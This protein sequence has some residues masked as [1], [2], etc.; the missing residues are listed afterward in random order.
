MLNQFSRTPT[1]LFVQATRP[2]CR[3]VIVREATTQPICVAAGAFDHGDPE[4]LAERVRDELSS[5]GLSAARAVLLLPRG[6]VEVNSLRLPPASDDEL[7]EMVANML[8]QQSD[9]EPTVHDFIVSDESAEDG[10][11][12]VL[13]FSVARHVLDTWLARFRDQNIRLQAVT[14]G[15]I[16]AVRLLGEVSTNPA[17]T[18]VVV[19][20]TD[21]D[22]DLVVIESAR[23][24]LFRTIPRATGGEQ[25]VIDQLAGDIQRTLNLVG[26]PN[27]EQTRVYLIGTVGEQEDAAKSLSDKLSLSVS[28]VNPFE[29]L[30]GDA[31]VDK[32]SRFANL[33]GT[34]TAW[35]SDKLSVDLLNPRRPAAKPGVV[36]RYGFWGAV[37]ACLLALGGYLLWEQNQEQKLMVEEQKNQLKRLI[38]PVK[39]ARQKELIAN[40]VDAWRAN[41]VN[42]LDELKLLSDRMPPASDATV[43][44][45]TLA[46]GNGMGRMDMS[47]E[48]SEPNVRMA[49]EE[50]ILD[51]RHAI[52]SKRVTDASNRSSTAFR[53]QTVVTLKP[54]PLKPLTKIVD[55]LPNKEVADRPT[56]N[57]AAPLLVAESN[58]ESEVSD[59]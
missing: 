26:Q 19:T 39:R 36:S 28:L 27:D 2:T 22:T 14:F 49:L 17:R 50:A 9:D 15:G 5:K 6:D 42:W 34:A 47:V 40:A 37:A 11:L 7:P 8:A 21:Q 53:F 16:G 51:E 44:S 4:T 58:P 52:R 24:V 43:G 57:D 33:I 10:S 54:A 56:D 48:V 55:E 20:T 41:E 18:S 30:R 25:F 35:N 29:Q 59:E 45:L 46:S 32:P 1:C 13:T 38:K 31:R 3:Y 23:P 12:D